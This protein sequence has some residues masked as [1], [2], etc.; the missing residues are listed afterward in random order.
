MLQKKM[1][2]ISSVLRQC[3]PLQGLYAPYHPTIRSPFLANASE[4]VT[5]KNG[6]LMQGNKGGMT[7]KN[8]GKT[9]VK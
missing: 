5:W 8:K 2:T 3:L 1:R 4:L 9:I 7:V 6:H